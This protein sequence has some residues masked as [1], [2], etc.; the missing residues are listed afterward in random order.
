MNLKSRVDQNYTL[1]NF[2]KQ[3]TESKYKNRKRKSKYLDGAPILTRDW[4]VD[5]ESYKD[6]ISKEKNVE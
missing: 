6:K 3:N 4:H 5:W 1:I 2:K